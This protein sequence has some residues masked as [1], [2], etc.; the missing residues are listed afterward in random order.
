MYKVA[1]VY[2]HIIIGFYRFQYQFNLLLTRRL[3]IL[4]QYPTQYAAVLDVIANNSSDS[5]K[6]FTLI[7]H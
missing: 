7:M 2:P 3:C 1:L 4:T 6:N 5:D